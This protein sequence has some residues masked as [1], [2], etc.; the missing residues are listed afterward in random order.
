MAVG[1]LSL[2]LMMKI[3]TVEVMGIRI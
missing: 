1:I 3:K 2:H